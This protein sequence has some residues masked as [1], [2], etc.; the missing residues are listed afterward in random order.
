MCNYSLFLRRNDMSSVQSQS[1]ATGISPR[2]S[3]LSDSQF[4]SYVKKQSFSAYESLDAGLT[5]KTNEGDLVTLSSNTFSK[6]DTSLYNSKGVLQTDAGKVM[7]T[8]NQRQITLASG[9]S[10][11]FSV[12]GNLS[13]EELKDVE[14]IVKGIDEVIS[15]MAEGD[16]EDA[17]DAALS[18]GG[19]DSIA[20]YS[21]DITYEK[22]YSMASEIEA[23]TI[24]PTP[25]P[26]PEPA[27]EP[28]TL[29]QG[30]N[31]APPKMEPFPENRRPWKNKNN[32]LENLDKFVEKM[33]DKIDKLDEKLMDKIQKPIDKL[34]RHHLGNMKENRDEERSLYNAVEKAGQ[35]IDKVI[36]KIAGKLFSNK[37]SSF[38]G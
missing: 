34:F 4:S 6:L 20:A 15:E 37:L 12:E 9:E 19:Y 18:M 31:A 3:A 35:E 8:Q 14:A 33:T 38:F 36:D 25:Q 32:S 30:N 21:A 1:L 22:S 11:T 28:A 24:E 16:M 2:Q 10:F 17:V 27:P 26:D 23:K 7:V 13:E 29:P 5:I